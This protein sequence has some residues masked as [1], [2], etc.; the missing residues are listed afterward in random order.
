MTASVTRVLL[1]RHGQSEWNVS[2]RWQGQTDPPLTDLGR[3]QAYSAARSLGTVDAIWASDLQR[4]AETAAIISGELGVGPVVLDTDLRERDAGE[5]QGLTRAEIDEQYPGY[6]EPPPDVSGEGWVPRRPP[7]WESD[8]K[9]MVR[10]RRSLLRIRRE[11]G[12]GEVLVV[13]H[14]GLL[15]LVERSLG[16]DGERLANLDGR[17]IDLTDGEDLVDGADTPHLS[18]IARLGDRINLL[19]PEQITIPGQI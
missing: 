11:V 7:G 16:A 8:D 14:A 4:A 9:L 12:P 13:A 17:W 2:G 3:R 1:V 18:D 6:L 15:F 10:M 19:S 5:W